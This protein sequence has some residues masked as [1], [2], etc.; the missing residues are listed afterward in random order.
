MTDELLDRVS[1]GGGILDR[2]GGLT[3]YTDLRPSPCAMA[4]CPGVTDGEHRFCSWCAQTWPD[5]SMRLKLSIDKIKEEK[6]G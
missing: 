3:T 4:A 1:T 6:N 2:A 5:L